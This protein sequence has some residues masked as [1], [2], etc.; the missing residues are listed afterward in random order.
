M[1]LCGCVCQRMGYGGDHRPYMLYS[2]FPIST[3]L[4]SMPYIL[5]K[6]THAENGHF[7]SNTTHRATRH[8]RERETK[9]KK[10]ALNCFALRQPQTD[11]R[12]GNA[13]GGGRQA[14]VCVSMG[15]NSTLFFCSAQQ[16]HLLVCTATATATATTTTT[17]T[18][19]LTTITRVARKEGTD[20]RHHGTSGF[21]CYCERARS[22]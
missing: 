1:I 17:T 15:H 21:G 7:S 18:T 3:C 10:D 12:Q 2:T 4:V 20:T 11:K 5:W 13:G 9:L 8:K 22:E 14:R 16:R 6:K 19:T